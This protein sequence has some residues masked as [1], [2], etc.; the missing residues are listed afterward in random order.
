MMSLNKM[1]LG[2][3]LLPVVLSAQTHDT[4]R[5]ATRK[6]DWQKEFAEKDFSGLWLNEDNTIVVGFCGESYERARVKF[7]SVTKEKGTDNRYYVYGKT[8]VGA[9][10]HVFRGSMIIN[11]IEAYKQM[12]YGVDDEH[13]DD[14]MKGQ[15]R[16]EGDYVFYE[17]STLSQTGKL[18]GRFTTRFYVDRNGGIKYMDIDD[19]ADGFNNN[20]FEGKWTG[21]QNKV[22]KTF[23]WGDYR[24]P[25]SRGLD[26]GAGEFSPDTK[27]LPYGWKSYADAYTYGDSA[28]LKE[29]KARWW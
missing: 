14:G 8:K 21:Y 15:Y 3:L 17:D 16:M 18:Y 12:E 27:Y 20:Q 22:T 23:N 26:I 24:I 9:K 10:V 19:Y 7:I 29:E 1:L 6:I 13:K 5:G 4:D 2:L 11:D 25:N 28:A